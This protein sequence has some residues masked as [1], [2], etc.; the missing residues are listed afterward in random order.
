MRDDALTR[1][2]RRTASCRDACTFRA[3]RQGAI[4]PCRQLP[5]DRVGGLIFIAAL[6]GEG[7][8]SGFCRETPRLARSRSPSALAGSRQATGRRGRADRLGPRRARAVLR[9]GRALD[10]SE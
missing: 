5:G 1:A 10:G 8:N 3:S 4:D 7:I 6:F 9:G 2:R